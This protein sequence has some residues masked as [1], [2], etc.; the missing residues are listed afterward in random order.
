MN[1]KKLSFEDALKKLED[2]V[3]T[4]E[5]GDIPLDEAIKLF[6]EGIKTSKICKEKLEGAE[7]KIKELIKNSDGTFSLSDFQFEMK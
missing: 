6:E 7:K 5:K 4:L 2:I 1:K 3:D